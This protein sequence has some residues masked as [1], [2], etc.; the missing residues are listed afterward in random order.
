M[1]LTVGDTDLQLFFEYKE[2]EITRSGSTTPV[3]QICCKIRP[4]PTQQGEQTPVIAE[5]VASCSPL[6]NFEKGTGR[7]IA[8][9]RALEAGPWDK[10]QREQFWTWYRNT[11]RDFKRGQEPTGTSELTIPVIVAG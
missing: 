11:T 2:G 3:R 10:A 7:R 5:G 6:D 8:L 9:Q 4:Y 1:K